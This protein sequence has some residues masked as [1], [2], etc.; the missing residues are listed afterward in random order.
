MTECTVEVL[1][2]GYLLKNITITNYYNNFL[3]VSIEKLSPDKVNSYFKS[4]FEYKD[5]FT[6]NV[7]LQ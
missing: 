3:K 1:N 4:S 5:L 6:C 2:D 7:N